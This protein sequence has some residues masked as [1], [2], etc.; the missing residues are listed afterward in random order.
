VVCLV[1]RSGCGRRDGRRNSIA[2]HRLAFISKGEI[3]PD[4]LKPHTDLLQEFPYLGTPLPVR[5]RWGPR[6]HD[7]MESGNTPTFE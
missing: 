6:P 3:P 2:A 7:W 1:G 4:G 5:P